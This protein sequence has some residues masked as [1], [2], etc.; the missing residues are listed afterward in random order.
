MTYYSE[1]KKCFDYLNEE[2]INAK[3]KKQKLNID[4]LLLNSQNKFEISDLAIM[5]RLRL[6][7][8]TKYIIIKG[9]EIEVI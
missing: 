1:R 2:L 5:K 8:K 7:E 3:E 4:E 9:D 6:L